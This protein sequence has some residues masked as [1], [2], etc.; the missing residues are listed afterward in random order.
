MSE[1]KPMTATD[2]GLSM[3]EGAAARILALAAQETEPV[4]LRVQVMG[5]GC[6]GFQ[7]SFSLDQTR[8]PDDLTLE[9]DGARLL[10][11][12]MSIALLQGS[13]IDWHEDVAGAM[14]VIANPNATASCGC[15]TSFS[16]G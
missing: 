3:T 9:R 5:G 6:S 1:I 13:E 11:D 10:I 8:N 14:F 12:E 16:I 2:Y 4:S 7:Y 15:G